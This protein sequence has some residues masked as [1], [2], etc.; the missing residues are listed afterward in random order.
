MQELQCEKEKIRKE[1]GVYI[2]ISHLYHVQHISRLPL[3]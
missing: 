3:S 1:K 2:P